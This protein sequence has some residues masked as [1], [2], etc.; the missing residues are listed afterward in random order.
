MIRSLQ[1]AMMVLAALPVFTACNA[2]KSPKAGVEP[3]HAQAPLSE[4]SPAPAQ[5]DTTIATATMDAPSAEAAPTSEDDTGVEQTDASG[6]APVA[7]LAPNGATKSLSQAQV[8]AAYV[9][10]TCAQ[11]AGQASQLA[12]IY[13]THGVKD[14]ST[15]QAIWRDSSRDA[16]VVQRAT[17]RAFRVCP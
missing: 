14:R 12:G 8:V 7:P 1:F 5:R 10:V 3:A 4:T 11:K 6:A 17:E 13:A 9:A 2:K 15:W 16:A